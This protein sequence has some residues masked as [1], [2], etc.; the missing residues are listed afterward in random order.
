ML[1]VQTVLLF[2]LS[3]PMYYESPDRLADEAT[4]YALSAR[5]VPA[6][7]RRSAQGLWTQM[8]P[9]GVGRP[10]QGWK[11]HISAVPDEASSTLDIVADACLARR[12]PFKFLRSAR[13]LRFANGKYMPRASS[14]KF[15]TVYPADEGQLDDLLAE[16]V[17]ALDG[18]RG[19]Y[20]LSDLRIG[21]G[22]VYVRYGAFTELW[23][24]GADGDPV[25]AV[26]DPAG[27]LVPDARVAGFTIPNGVRV[28]ASLRSH[29]AAR[30]PAEGADLPYRVER[31]LYFTNAGGTYLA[32]DRETGQR[33]VLREARPHCGTDSTG[34]DAV[35]RLRR[36]YEIL[37]R[38]DGLDFVPR[39]HGLRTFWEHEFL[40]EQYVPGQ[41]F[42]DAVVASH[43]LRFRDPAPDVL[44]GYARW[45]E[46]ITGELG[47]ALEIL[48]DRGVSHGD[49]HP[50]NVILRP[51]G[52]VALLDFEYAGAAGDERPVRVGA[53]GFAAPGPVTGAEADWYA[54]RSTWLMAML[55]LAEVVD[56]DPAKAATLRSAAVEHLGLGPSAGSALRE[57]RPSS[58]RPR[59][60]EPAVAELFGD[61]SRQWPAIRA[62]LVDAILAAATPD[63]TDRLF[64]GGPQVFD[65]QAGALAHGAA[66]VLLALHRAGVA[67]PESYVDWLVAAAGRT[68]HRAG[69]FDGLAGIAVVLAELG[70]PDEALAAWSRCRELPAPATADLQSG[71]AGRAW[72]SCRFADLTGDEGLLDDAIRAA[73]EL[74]AVVRDGGGAALALAPSAGLLHGMSGAAVVHLGLYR[75][76][77]DERHLRACRRALSHELSHCVA[78]EDGTVLVKAGRRHLLYLNAGSGGIALVANAYLA[79]REDDELAAFVR[80]VRRGCGAPMVREPG[81]WH[82]RA[83]LLAMLGR[84]GGPREEVL[85]QV[86]RL[87]WHAVCRDGHLLIPGHRLSRFSADLATG[88]AGVLLALH[89]VL[90]DEDTVAGHDD[91]L[92]LLFP[93]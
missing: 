19:P 42:M 68:R 31:V 16:L 18:R 87:A 79:H 82:G 61:P 69:L 21:A 65:G 38:L 78:M 47:R 13:A 33:V 81:L 23:C 90:G 4:R 51:D 52:S 89:T 76:T 64:P 74:D 9:E 36:E 88:S 3:D 37:S 77:A 50:S 26:R 92:P 6:G 10:E 22:P 8:R 30:A 85:D 84:L 86:R 14:G 46:R 40:V 93:R 28:P 15:I 1:N 91:A 32:V 54:L 63:R 49:V 27:R 59:S 45:V 43:P 56:H 17:P 58:S 75:R 2:C 44:S 25:P 39:V 73:A 66:G 48:H 80:A 41:T 24:A 72:T 35:T 5:P 60:G 53:P 29:L 70:R 55:P 83:G 20:I 12:V 71:L 67:V 7:W 11:I 62:G 34:T 57:V